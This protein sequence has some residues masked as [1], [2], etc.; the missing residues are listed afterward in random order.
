MNVYDALKSKNI[1]ELSEWFDECVYFED[2]PWARYFDDN[3]CKKCKPEIDRISEWDRECECAWCE[4][5]GQCKYFQD[6]D[7]IPSNKEI[8][9]M[10][11]E[12]EVEE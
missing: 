8:I 5:N 10:W 9:K 11:L 6:M 4:L 3:Y 2:S 12:S 7:D 1:D